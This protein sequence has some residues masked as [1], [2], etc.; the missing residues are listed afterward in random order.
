VS[1][2]R[3]R[4]TIGRAVWELVTVAQ[5]WFYAEDERSVGPLSVDALTG[6]LRRMAEPG[7]TL[8]WR[9]GLGDW[10]PASDIPELAERLE[11][12]PPVVAV[13]DPRMDRWTVTEA[14]P[15]SADDDDPLATWKRRAAYVA[16]I[17]TLAAI[18]A[19]GVIYP[20]RAFR[21]LIEPEARVVL[22]PAPAPQQPE[23][24]VARQ[25][26]ATVLAQLTG[27]AAQAAAATDAIARKLWASIEPPGMQTPPNYATASRSD[28]EGYFTDLE[29]AEA[30]A[31]DAEAQYAALLKA[32]RDLIEET[33]RSSGLAESEWMP[34]MASVVERQGAAREL[35]NRM[36][37]ARGDLY[38]AMQGMQA[39]V[40]DQFGKYK[41]VGDGQIRF[42]SKAMT[43][44]MVAATE[45]VNAANRALD[46]VEDEMMKARQLPQQAPEPAWKDMVIKDRAATPQ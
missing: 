11:T 23:K 3:K 46:R 45:E 10:R 22:P 38:R 25:D 32:E 18:V 19:A 1:G 13:P 16:A 7:K 34:L 44:R 37:K 9:A 29:T 40:I 27:K 43:D 41:T 17:A 21:P 6:A 15:D 5:E 12:E 35:A 28:L 31:A 26:P 42:S 4:G 33:A 8:V 30:N 24:E 36:L 20:P 14:V 2:T 39:I